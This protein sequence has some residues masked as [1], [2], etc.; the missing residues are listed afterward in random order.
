M[1]YFR[2][3]DRVVSSHIFN[4]P[5]NLRMRSCAV[6]VNL[7]T[8]REPSIDHLHSCKALVNTINTLESLQSESGGYA[9]TVRK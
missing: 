7:C 1:S 3:F 2:N 9:E 4:K 6:K 8:D 5:N